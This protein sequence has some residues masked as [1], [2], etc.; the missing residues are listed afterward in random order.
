MELNFPFVTLGFPKPLLPLLKYKNL[1]EFSSKIDTNLLHPVFLKAFSYILD[2]QKPDYEESFR[3]LLQRRQG[4]LLFLFA[5][6]QR[7]YYH[8]LAN[9]KKESFTASTAR[10]MTARFNFQ[11]DELPHLTKL[12]GDSL[13]IYR[14][15][16]LYSIKEKEET[17]LPQL[18]S[19]ISRSDLTG[20]LKEFDERI[21]EPYNDYIEKINPT[22]MTDFSAP[23]ENACRLKILAVTPTPGN[24]SQHELEQHMLMEAFKGFDRQAVLLDIPESIK[25]SFECL[26]QLLA[27]GEH[28][29][30]YIA[31]NCGISGDGFP[32]LEFENDDGKTVLLPPEQLTAAFN[33]APKILFLNACKS[34]YQQPNLLP[35]A[36]ALFNSGVNTVISF[37]DPLEY[38]SAAYFTLAFF[39]SFLRAAPLKEAFSDACTQLMRWDQQD[40]PQLLTREE[41]MTIHDFHFHSIEPPQ[42]SSHLSPKSS[43]AGG[44]VFIGRQKILRQLYRYVE[45]KEGLIVLD[46]ARGIGKTTIANRVAADLRLQGYTIITIHG[47]QPFA[48]IMETF[49]L[50]FAAVQGTPDNVADVVYNRHDTIDDKLDIFIEHFFLKYKVLIIFD[51][52]DP[53]QSPCL[54]T[55]DPMFYKQHL[56]KYLLLMRDALRGMDSMMII[57]STEELPGFTSVKLTELPN[58]E[59]RK[60]LFQSRA[61]KHLDADTAQSLIRKAGSNPLALK[62]ADALAYKQCGM[63]PVTRELALQVFPW[64][65]DERLAGRTG[66]ETCLPLLVQSLL[67]YLSDSQRLLLESLSI[68]KTPQKV[69]ELLAHNFPI[70]TED[71][72]TLEALLL[73]ETARSVG[74]GYTYNLHPAISRRIRSKTSSSIVTGRHMEA[75]SFLEKTIPVSKK[76]HIRL[77]LERRTHLLKARQWDKA[78]EATFLLNDFL[79]ANGFV[80]LAQYFFRHLLGP[81]FNRMS[82]HQRCFLFSRLANSFMESADFDQALSF[83]GKTVKLALK[84]NFDSDCP[85]FMSQLGDAQLAMGSKKEALIPLKEGARL[86]AKYDNKEVLAR[87]QFGIGKCCETMSQFNEAQEHYENALKGARA[88]RLFSLVPKIL[89]RMG[90]LHL[91]ELRI[92]DAH[93]YF[94]E[95]LENARKEEDFKT[96]AS[97]MHRLGIL[98]ET[99]SNLEEAQDFYNQSL[100]VA[101]KRYLNEEIARNLAA[102][103]TLSQTSENSETSA[104]FQR[105]MEICKEKDTEVMAE[106]AYRIGCWHFTQRKFLPALEL[107]IQVYSQYM[108]EVG[109]GLISANALREKV[110]AIRS[111]VSP[112]EFKHVMEKYKLPPDSLGKLPEKY[113]KMVA[114]LRE[115]TAEVIEV[116]ELSEKKKKKVFKKLVKNIESVEKSR[117]MINRAAYFYFKMLEA[118]LNKENYKEYKANVPGSFMQIFRDVGAKG[119]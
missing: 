56:E 63:Q 24:D 97:S 115:I 71:R 98:A 9:V 23:G 96:M 14:A 43:Q 74:T 69:S 28:E 91:I 52:F 53:Q 67:E 62:L 78:V 7:D 73:I 13:R 59:A 6:L 87:C 30:L 89:Y 109:K 60:M 16:F 18:L 72:E 77:L 85:L 17:H 70:N 25:G 100:E 3:D 104:Y 114:L 5:D 8:F 82:D 117:Q 110:T 33:P 34:D 41:K 19:G 102:L 40:T 55:P 50:Y 11:E 119:R 39:K 83:A 80:R 47:A 12:I 65:E 93:Y 101:K 46:G 27:E 66:R 113:L 51:D 88:T 48:M 108:G 22:V 105:A 111:M 61:L 35:T 20:A 99:K 116:K 68:Y 95:A 15:N 45:Q 112:K 94:K 54:T 90:N 42:R 2:Q 44:P 76:S 37:K 49:N 36:Q 1:K 103:G 10:A 38:K 29:V 31:C 106:I 79:E 4:E 57:C 118:W 64:L 58:I 21:L 81:D 86:A 107:L 32:V 84:N 75:A 26:T 92:E